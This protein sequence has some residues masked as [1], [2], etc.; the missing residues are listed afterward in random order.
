MKLSSLLRLIIT[1][2]CLLFIK[3][4]S[5][6]VIFLLTAYEGTEDISGQHVIDCRDDKFP[7]AE[8][9]CRFSDQWL[10]GGNCHKAEK[11]GYNRESP[12]IL[13]KLNKVHNIFLHFHLS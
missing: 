11:W 4:L 12:C 13:L 6:F 8:Q 9:V 2:A 5:T 3:F 10:Q 7:D 1:Y